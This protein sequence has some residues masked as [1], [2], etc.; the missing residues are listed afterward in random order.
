LQLIAPAAAP[1]PNLAGRRISAARFTENAVEMDFG[2]H[3]ISIVGTIV[4]VSGSTRHVYPDS[5]SRDAL[6]ATIGTRVLSVRALPG[7]RIEVG[8]DSAVSLII[9]RDSTSAADEPPRRINE[10]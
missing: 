5:G 3:R 10:S 7:D 2:G 9:P 4:V 6:C 8:L 1:L